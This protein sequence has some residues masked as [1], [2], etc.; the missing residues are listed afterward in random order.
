MLEKVHEHIVSELQQGARTVT[1]VI[2]TAIVYN[3]VAWWT[4]RLLD[5]GFAPKI[6]IKIKTVLHFG[7]VLRFYRIV[8]LLVCCF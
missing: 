1:I 8:C 6:G 4:W 2:T 5:F 3:R 7:K